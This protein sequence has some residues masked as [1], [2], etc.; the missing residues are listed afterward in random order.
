MGRLPNGAERARFDAIRDALRLRDD[1]AVWTLFVALEYYLNL[2]ERFP[3][4]IRGAARELLIECKTERPAYRP[5]ETAGPTADG[6]RRRPVAQAAVAAHAS[7]GNINNP[8]AGSRSRRFRH[9]LALGVGW[10]GG[11]GGGVD[12]HR[13]AVALGFGRQQGTRPV[14]AGLCRGDATWQ[15]PSIAPRFRRRVGAV[16]AD[17]PPIFPQNVCPK[18]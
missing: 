2:Y 10:R 6:N 1:D 13:R 12:P 3:A 18:H 17:S 16:A 15:R 9:P 5:R 8:P 7:L 11:D 14:M 4:M